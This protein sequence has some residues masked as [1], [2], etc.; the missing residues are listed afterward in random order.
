[1]PFQKLFPVI[2]RLGSPKLRRNLAQR[3][4]LKSIRKLAGMIDIMDLTAQEIW[5]QKKEAILRDEASVQQS[6]HGKDL[7]SV[8]ST[9]VPRLTRGFTVDIRCSKS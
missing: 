2:A 7:M 6:G 8:M 5:A 1:M 3:A 9:S 4:P